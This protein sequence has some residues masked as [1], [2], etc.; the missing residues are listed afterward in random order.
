MKLTTKAKRQFRYGLMAFSLSAMASPSLYAADDILAKADLGYGEYLSGECVTCH[1]KNGSDQGI[2]SITGLDAEGFA[3]IMLAY[4]NK[5]LDNNVMQTVAGRLD[6]EQ[7]A[8]L[9]VYFASLPA[10]E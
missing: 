10:G 4:R 7:I 1:Q 6:D 5:E 8:S 2:P 3:Q 9:A